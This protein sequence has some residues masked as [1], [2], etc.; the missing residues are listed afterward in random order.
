M[1]TAVAVSS[2]FIGSRI[3]DADSTVTIPDDIR[4]KIETLKVDIDH[5]ELKDEKET[6]S[7]LAL[8]QAVASQN[9]ESTKKTVTKV[10]EDTKKAEDDLSAATKSE[11]EL[12][13]QI[14]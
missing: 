5:P 2:V 6:L 11:E 14:Q 10:K 1:T 7:N 4:E 8:K 3:V 12:Q 9:L 13:K